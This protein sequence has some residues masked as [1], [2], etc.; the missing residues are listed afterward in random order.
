M[1]KFK[2]IMKDEMT[3]Y[4]IQIKKMKNTSVIIKKKPKVTI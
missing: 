3:G 2:K 4:H 1:A